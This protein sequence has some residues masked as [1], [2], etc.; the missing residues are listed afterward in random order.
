VQYWLRYTG[1]T[2]WPKAREFI[3][4]GLQQADAE[5]SGVFLMTAL[6]LTPP[7]D[8]AWI[9]WAERTYTF[10]NRVRLFLQK[11]HEKK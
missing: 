3:E 8:E 7:P 5:T 6:D 1:R 9:A 2:G 11:R 4:S 10:S